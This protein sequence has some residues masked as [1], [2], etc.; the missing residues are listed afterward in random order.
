MCACVEERTPALQK[1]LRKRTFSVCQRCFERQGDTTHTWIFPS[2][3]PNMVLVALGSFQGLRYVY[4]CIYVCMPV[5]LYLC[6]YVC[7]YACMYVCVHVCIM[8]ACMY[9]RM[10]V[11]MYV[12]TYVCMH[13]YLCMSVH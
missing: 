7:M 8:Y 9:V 12:C 6:T 3:L 10:Y 2:A 5:C 4:V 11:C 1:E 13:V